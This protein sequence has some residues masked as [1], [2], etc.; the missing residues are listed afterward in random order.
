MKET[1]RE[2]FDQKPLLLKPEQAA[3]MLNIGRPM[4]FKLISEGELKSLKMGRLRL[5]PREAVEQLIERR[6]DV[7]A[8]SR[9]RKQ[10]LG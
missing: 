9:F 4:L 8:E 2:G 1:S 6:L 3:A 10:S 5:I 7:E